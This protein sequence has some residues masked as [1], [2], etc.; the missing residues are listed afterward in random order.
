MLDDGVDVLAGCVVGEFFADCGGTKEAVL[1]CVLAADSGDC[2]WFVGGAVPAPY[3]ATGCTS[4][5]CCD[6][7]EWPLT[8]ESHYPYGAP[9]DRAL[10]GWGTD[11][12]DLNRALGVDVVVNPAVV[13][14]I[15]FDCSKQCTFEFERSPCCGYTEQVAYLELLDTLVIWP[16]TDQ[17][18]SGWTPV[19]EIVPQQAKARIC[20]YRFD[21]VIEFECPSRD[22]LCASSGAL[23]LTAIPET[24]ADAI[25]IEGKLVATFDGFSLSGSFAITSADDSR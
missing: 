19:I 2:R 3:Q 15:P 4:D 13:A 25:G 18:A 7:G 23:E 8:C 12:W 10:Q 17:G 6:N 5:G 20:A 24:A 9:L 1:A 14:D 16:A 21:D 11:P 22:V